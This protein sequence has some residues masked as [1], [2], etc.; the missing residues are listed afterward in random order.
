MCTD[1]ELITPLRSRVRLEYGQ[2]D[3]LFSFKDSTV[4]INLKKVNDLHT[5]TDA[6]NYMTKLGW[7][8]TG[9]TQY[10][11]F[12]YFYFRKSFDEGELE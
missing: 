1:R 6:I 3:S 7:T 2:A 5:R 10:R 4:L 9:M 8:L 12:H 11:N